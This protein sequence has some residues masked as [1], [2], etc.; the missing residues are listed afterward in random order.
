M[1]RIFVILAVVSLVAFA[2]LT[3]YEDRTVIRDIDFAATVK[4]QERIDTSARLRLSAAVGNVLEGTAFF[5]GPLISSTLVIVITGYALIR[6][7]KRPRWAALF[8]PVCFAGIVFVEFIV[9]EIVQHPPPPFF[10]IK[11]PSTIF[12]RY[13][14]SGDFSYPSG[15]AARAAFLGIVT[16]AAFIRRRAV[17]T[18]KQM[19]IMLAVLSVYVALVSVSKIYLGHHWASDVVGGLLLG[20]GM[21]SISGSVL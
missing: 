15:H 8:I 16:V 20:I 17:A 7:G 12:P 18:R 4:L 2:V 13:Y 21:G 9:K 6:P 1:K 11:N 5:A 19:V 14:V 3:K 10:M